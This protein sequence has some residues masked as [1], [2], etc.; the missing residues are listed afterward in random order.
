MPKISKIAIA[1]IIILITI[2]SSLV[3]AV[4]RLQGELTRSIIV[5]LT[6]KQLQG[7]S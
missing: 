6:Y 4:V 1:L 5:T 7:T 3:I 2:I